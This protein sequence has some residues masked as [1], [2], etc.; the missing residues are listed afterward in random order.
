[1]DLSTLSI[2]L[3]NTRN[4]FKIRYKVDVDVIKTAKAVLRELLKLEEEENQ[5]LI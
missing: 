2:A 3:T 4:F 1:M 5:V